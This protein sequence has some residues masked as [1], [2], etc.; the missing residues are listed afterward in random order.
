MFVCLLVCL[1]VCLHS[2]MYVRHFYCSNLEYI[3]YSMNHSFNAVSTSHFFVHCF[4]LANFLYVIV[5]LGHLLIPPPST[6]LIVLFPFISHSSECLSGS[7]RF[8]SSLCTFLRHSEFLFPISTSFYLF[9]PSSTS[10]P[11]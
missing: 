5:F 2:F 10:S 9:T 7:F 3:L 11:P 8:H 4:C 1:L 6:F